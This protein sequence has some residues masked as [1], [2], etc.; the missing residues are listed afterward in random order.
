MPERSPADGPRPQVLFLTQVLPHPPDSGPKIRT[1]N[2]LLSLARHADVTLVSFVREDA[3]D[4]RAL[5]GVCRAVHTVRMRRGLARDVWHLGRSLVTRRPFTILRDERRAM[6]ALVD[7]LVATRRFDVVHADQMY[8]AQYAALV[9]DVQRVL[10]AHNAL[11]LLYRQLAA[12]SPPGPRRLLLA[13]ESRLMRAYEGRVCRAFD[14]VIAV[15]AVDRRALEAAIGRPSEI[16]VVPIAVDTD[17]LR[18]MRRARGDRILHVGTMYWPPNV[19]AVRWFA[20]AILPRVRA[21][22]PGV[23]FD[24]LGARPP[25]AIRRL[26]RGDAGITVH[27]YVADLTPHLEQAAVVVVPLRAG[28]GMRVKILEALALGIPVVTTSIGCEG[29]AI[30]PG[31]HALVADTPEDFAAATLR[32]LGDPGV[33]AALAREG[34]AL[35]EARY[36]AQVAAPML[37][38]V[39]AR[40]ARETSAA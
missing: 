23:R 36:A 24:V 34:R 11:W 19:D 39:Y 40:L 17:A 16:A 26:V 7:R 38:D 21:R 2:L 8:M 27:G 9:P 32:V 15:S 33:A 6:A 37:L 18:P 14:A 29:I 5:E 31:R 12:L 25:R 30:E 22:R 4:V 10:D 1:W 20:E 13:R 28:S 3:P 35:V